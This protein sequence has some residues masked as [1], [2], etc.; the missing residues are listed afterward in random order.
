MSETSQKKIG[1][2]SMI[3]LCLNSIVGSGLFLL[4]GQVAAIC[5][6]WGLLV[7]AGV[8][9]MVMSIGWCYAQCAGHY[10]RNGGAYLY[11]KEAF[12]DFIGFE[13]GLMRWVVSIIAWA[14]LTSGLVLA[15]GSLWAEA[16]LYPT[17][18]FLT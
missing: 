4:P 7:Y 11:A 16:L 10:T 2:I 17:K 6:N 15:L 12:G 1:L 13:V 5:G 14:S 3:F 8:A 9:L 18:Q